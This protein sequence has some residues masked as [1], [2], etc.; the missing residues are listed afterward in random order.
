MRAAIND[1]S[2]LT[3]CLQLDDLMNRKLTTRIEP[4]DT[5][6]KLVIDLIHNGF[7]SEVSQN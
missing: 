5:A 7:I 6:E 1:S 4:E 2:M 3:I